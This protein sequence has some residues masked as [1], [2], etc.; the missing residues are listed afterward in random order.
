MCVNFSR[1]IYLLVTY[2]IASVAILLYIPEAED[3]ADACI[4]LSSESA[5]SIT[6]VLIPVDCGALA[7]EPY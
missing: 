6:G 4:F 5:S 7:A 3:I 1:R 2:I